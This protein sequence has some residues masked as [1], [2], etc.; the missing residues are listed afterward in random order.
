[1][2]RKAS[3]DPALEVSPELQMILIRQQLAGW[4]VKKGGAGIVKLQRRYFYIAN[5]FFW[6]YALSP[7]EVKP[8]GDIDLRTVNKVELLPLVDEL[9]FIVVSDARPKPYILKAATGSEAKLWVTC[10]LETV[11]KLK[12]RENDSVARYIVVK[13]LDLILSCLITHF[14]PK[15]LRHSELE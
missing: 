6:S 1:M 11:E 5:R 7:N 4:L 2:S 9:S 13:L 12:I 10:I 3:S 8:K 14:I 15:F